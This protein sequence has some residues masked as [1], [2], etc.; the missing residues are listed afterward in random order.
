MQTIKELAKEL[1]EVYSL[2]TTGKVS[3]W[4]RL[5]DERKLSWMQEA[6][7][8]QALVIQNL[9]VRA[10]LAKPVVPEGTTSFALGLSEGTLKERIRVLQALDK[11]DFDNTVEVEDF[12]YALRESAHRNS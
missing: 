1:F 10:G 9:R 11:L 12:E 2:K 7:A 6:H 4:H 8:L 5:S 3:N